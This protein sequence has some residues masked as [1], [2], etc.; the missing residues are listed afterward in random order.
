MA[1]TKGDDND[2]DDGDADEDLF[3]PLMMVMPRWHVAPHRRDDQCA[4]AGGQCDAAHQRAA[5]ARVAARG[6]RDGPNDF[7][8]LDPL[9]DDQVDT[10]LGW[11]RERLP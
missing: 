4:S 5:R 9:A 8:D 3:W 10:P 11:P 6:H 7:T 2:G 1:A